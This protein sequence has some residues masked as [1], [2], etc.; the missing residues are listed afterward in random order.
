MSNLTLKIVPMF[1][2]GI[3]KMMPTYAHLKYDDELADF[4]GKQKHSPWTLQN[5]LALLFHTLLM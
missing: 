2:S 4:K 5:M 3:W 1:L